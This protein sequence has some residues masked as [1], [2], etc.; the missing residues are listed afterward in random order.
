MTRNRICWGLASRTFETASEQKQASKGLAANFKISEWGPEAVDQ[1]LQLDYVKNQK[2]PYGGTLQDLFDQTEKGTPVR[3][4]FEDKAFKTWYYKRTVLIGD[5]CHKLIP[6]SGVGALQAILD[7]I[8]LANALYDMPDGNS[9]TSADITRAFQVYYAQRSRAAEAAVKAS[10]QVSD[11][12]SN[13][14]WLSR[15]ARNATLANMPDFVLTLVGDRVFASRPILS[16]LPFVPDYGAR[17]SN[18]QPLGRRDR[19]ELE[20]LRLRERKM[21]EEAARAL[22]EEKRK[23]KKNARTAIIKTAAIS[24]STPTPTAATAPASTEES[25]KKNAVRIPRAATSSSF[26]SQPNMSLSLQYQNSMGK[27]SPDHSLSSTSTYS[28]ISADRLSELSFEGRTPAVALCRNNYSVETDAGIGVGGSGSI[29]TNNTNGA[30]HQGAIGTKSSLK[31]NGSCAYVADDDT[32]SISDSASI[33]SFSSRYTLP[34]SADDLEREAHV[35][36]YGRKAVGQRRSKD[37]MAH[38]RSRSHPHPHD[39]DNGH[40]VRQ[41]SMGSTISSLWYRYAQFGRPSTTETKTTTITP[42]DVPASTSVIALTA[43]GNCGHRSDYH[44]HT[45]APFMASAG[46]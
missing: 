35:Y 46:S 28:S 12:I 14:S 32:V 11:F 19:E 27:V 40:H 22:K 39:D 4:M 30:S 8:I 43:D 16:Y 33:F 31:N 29:S 42:I 6:F 41:D 13:T 3:I 2:S 15:M 21:K 24:A 36:C 23:V 7:C 1:I 45:D 17:K 20:S 25:L 5:A 9:F 44:R 37:K 26:V 34:Y 38:P 10:T 18:P